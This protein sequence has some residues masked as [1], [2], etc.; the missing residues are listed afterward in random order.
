M[1]KILVAEDDFAN[2]QV[3]TLFLKKFGYE[4]DIAENGL[5]ASKLAQK[6]KYQLI[7][8][9]CQMPEM[10]G[11]ESAKLIRS[12]KGPNQATPIIALTAN[13][14]VGIREECLAAGMNDILNKPMNINSLKE[15]T[16]KW[17]G[18]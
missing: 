13:V 5:E 11:F 1:N 15:I 8:M 10:D 7:F 2:Q 9:D 4:T 18:Q 6:E 16:E 14:V 3:T 17:I 12:L